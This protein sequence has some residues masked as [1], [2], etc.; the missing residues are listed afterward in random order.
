MAFLL[1]PHDSVLSKHNL[2]PKTETYLMKRLCWADESI[3]AN[4]SQS[5]DPLLQTITVSSPSN[6]SISERCSRINS[7][8][9][10]EWILAPYTKFTL[11]INCQISS[12]V[13]NCSAVKIKAN[14]G[15]VFHELQSKILEQSWESKHFQESL[16]AHGNLEMY[17]LYTGGLLLAIMVIYTGIRFLVK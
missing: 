16:P 15:N 2:E 5:E 12:E 11:P 6:I 10:R 9:Q 8:S 17:I 1:L 4:S 7:W 3:T 14:N 13:L